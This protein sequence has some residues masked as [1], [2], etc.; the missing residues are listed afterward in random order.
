MNLEQRLQHA[1]R[2]LREVQIVVPP[3]VGA[4][5]RPRPHSSATP[6]LVPLLFAAGALLAIG[7]AR[8]DEIG[9]VQGDLSAVTSAVDPSTAPAPVGTDHEPEVRSIEAPSA[10]VELQSIAE[11]DSSARTTETSTRPVPVG[12]QARRLA[13]GVGP[14]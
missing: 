2:D 13:R 9:T 10:L 12:T 1:S 7:A 5:P 11:F 8:T 3:L 4:T 14:V 6:L